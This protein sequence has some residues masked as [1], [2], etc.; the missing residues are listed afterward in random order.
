MSCVLFEG[1]IVAVSV[2]NKSKQALCLSCNGYMDTS[3]VMFGV[4]KNLLHFNIFSY[5]MQFVTHPLFFFKELSFFEIFEVRKSLSWSS[6]QK[7]YNWGIAASLNLRL[8][9]LFHLS[10]NKS[11]EAICSG[12]ILF[13]QQFFF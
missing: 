1:W 7:W 5:Y 9:I 12:G 6:E 4:L 11:F 3:Y 13:S 8:F 10:S 2:K